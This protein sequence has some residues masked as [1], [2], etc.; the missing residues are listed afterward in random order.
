M[1]K[2][3]LFTILFVAAASLACDSAIDAVGPETTPQFARSS[4][5]F[6]HKVSG[7]GQVDYVNFPTETYGFNASIDGD[8][9][10]KGQFESHWGSRKFHMD[11][12]CL[13]VAANKAWI[14]GVVTRA[15]AG[16]FPVGRLL[17]FS[18]VDNG[19]GKNADPD[20]LSFFSGR[21]GDDCTGQPDLFLFDW[22]RGNVQVK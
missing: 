9:N 14:G 19:Q 8:G 15:D 7:G 18:V 11:I 5:A 1:S 20:Q 3:A 17:I 21:F 2:S 4:T 16:F 12:T 10:V 6:V 13:S 22:A